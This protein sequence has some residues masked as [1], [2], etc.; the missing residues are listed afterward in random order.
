[1]LISGIGSDWLASKVAPS[2]VRTSDR[3]LGHDRHLRDVRV[4]PVREREPGGERSSIRRSLEVVIRTDQRDAVLARHR[5]QS[6]KVRGG[7]DGLVIDQVDEPGRADVDV[8]LHDLGLGERDLLAALDGRAAREHHGNRPYPVAYGARGVDHVRGV[9]ERLEKIHP[10]FEHV[11][12]LG[13]HGVHFGEH[14]VPGAT[15]KGRA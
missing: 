1:M 5:A 4:E 3:P 12:P 7:M 10:P 11:R 8:Q 2:S 15:D 9:A 6:A 13:Q 14:R